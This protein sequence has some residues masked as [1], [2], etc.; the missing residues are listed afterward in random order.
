MSVSEIVDNQ[1]DDH[2][3][4]HT[5]PGPDFYSSFFAKVNHRIWFKDIRNTLNSVSALPGNTY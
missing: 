1:N 3:T 2:G 5:I 4:A